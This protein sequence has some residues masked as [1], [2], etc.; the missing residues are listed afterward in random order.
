MTKLHSNDLHIKNVLNNIPKENFYLVKIFNN[1]H[2]IN[3]NR[4]IFSNGVAVVKNNKLA[5]RL[6]DI[7]FLESLEPES[8]KKFLR[9]GEILSVI[10]H[11]YIPRIYDILEYEELLLFRYEHVDGYSLREILDYFKKKKLVFPE[12]VA[13]AIVSKISQALYYAHNDVRYAGVKRS[14]IHCDIKPSNILISAKD[15]TRKGSSCDLDKKFIDL[16]NQNRIEPFLIDFGIATVQGK[17]NTSGTT[18]YLSFAQLTKHKLDWRT[19]IHQLLLVYYE[20]LTLKTPYSSLSR[21]KI[22]DEKIKQD[23]IIDKKTN[24]VSSVKLFIEKGTKRD[25]NHSFKSEKDYLKELS[26]IESRQRRLNSFKKY[27]KPLLL[28]TSMILLL[29]VLFFA[30]T[31]WDYKTQSIDAILTHIE[32]NPNPSIQDLE[33]AM[34]KLQKRSFEKKYYIPLI[35]GEFRDAKTGQLLYPSHLD[36]K[37]DWIL[38]G[39]ETE[40]AGLFVGLLFEYSDRYTKLLDYAKEYAEPILAGEFDGSGEKRF[41]YALISGYEKTHDERYLKK[42]INVSDTLIYHYSID[43]GTTQFND[44]YQQKL[45]LYVYNQTGDKKYLDFYNSLFNEFVKNN[46]D[47][48]GYVY[49]SIFSEELPE[50]EIHYSRWS[51][52]SVNVNNNPI[53]NYFELKNMTSLEFKDVTSLYTKDYLEILIALKEMR[54]V[55]S[56]NVNYSL[57]LN[58]TMHYYLLHSNIDNTDYLFISSYNVENNIPKDNLAT[59]KAT[60]FFKDINNEYYSSKL[61][62]L[63]SKDNFRKETEHGILSGNV[64]IENMRYDNTDLTLRNQT[65]IESDA[66]FLEKKIEKNIKI[67]TT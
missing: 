22:L 23:F 41:M 40:S 37:G 44:L 26:Q 47:N 67:L 34:V 20:L 28:F 43:P 66:L 55:D 63:L 54:N 65:L 50:G 39:S 53:G 27:K 46:I 3:K 17:I 2:N 21:K 9:E 56:I 30:Y 6:E 11:K 16:L 57:A 51:K 13:T 24:I 61:K 31:V 35:R 60:Y 14:I 1:Q 18:N 38:V 15:Y 59:I 32:N 19:D 5:G 10:N 48:D 8:R 29:I 62:A 52:L 58:N 49:L 12:N 45:F 64:F 4:S 33:S 42:L 7:K 25:T 36:S